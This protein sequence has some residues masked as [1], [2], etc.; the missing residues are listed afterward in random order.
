MN[1]VKYIINKNAKK[2]LLV[3]LLV[4]PAGFAVAQQAEFTYTQYM[5]N[6]TPLNPAYSLIDKA[7]SISTLGRK[8]FVGID[9]APATYLVNAN[10]PIESIN[11]AA[12]LILFN[13]VFAI[14][15]QTEINAYFAKAIQ[16]GQNDYLG[17]SLNAGV[18]NYFANYSSLSSTDPEFRADI[19]QTKPNIGF[20][21]MYFTD[22]YY[23]GISA[24]E[25][26]VTNLGTASV[27][28]SN[29]FQNHYYISGG[30]L[31]DGGEDLKFK[32]A[33]LLSYSQGLP[34]A[35]DF[36]CIMYLKDIVGIGFDYRTSNQAAGI[37]TINVDGFHIGYS[38][39]F[40]VASNDL[41][42]FN[43]PTNEVTLSYRFGPG[44]AN[45]KLL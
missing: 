41:G 26:T 35:A 25:L 28:G 19:R 39:Q 42:G 29:N 30:I 43:I 21:V 36:S 38:Y 27:Q 44:A 11:G 17:V 3:L 14:E 34:L 31:L 33:T 15:Q 7:G 24:P 32:P 2:I 10:L 23:V 5:D 18:R 37:L 8:E 40:N 20:G 45:P 9:G 16:L 1:T 6:L 22:T 13:D 4:L 12:G